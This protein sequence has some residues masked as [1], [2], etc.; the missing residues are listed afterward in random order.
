MV[1]SDIF[2]IKIV[3]V[4]RKIFSHGRCLAQDFTGQSF[5]LFNSS[6]TAFLLLD[7][8]VITELE[9]ILLFQEVDEEFTTTENLRLDDRNQEFLVINL[10]LLKLFFC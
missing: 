9:L 3:E 10:L 7:R 6:W 4:I 1:A 5:D 8:E 2:L